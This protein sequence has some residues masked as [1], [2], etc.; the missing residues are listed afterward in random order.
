MRPQ[1]FKRELRRGFGSL[2]ESDYQRVKKFP[3][4]GKLR[5]DEETGRVI[6]GRRITYD[7]R[8]RLLGLSSQSEFQKAINILYRRSNEV[9]ARVLDMTG[10]ENLAQ[11]QGQRQAEKWKV[12]KVLDDS[13]LVASPDGFETVV[14]KREVV[15]NLSANLHEVI[16]EGMPV[17]VTVKQV[18]LQEG[19][20]DLSL[21]K[22]EED[23]LNKYQI[24]QVANGHV[25]N[26]ISAGAFIELEPG[27]QG[28]VHISEVA[29]WRIERVEAILHKGQA[30][31]VRILD[32]DRQERKLSLTMRLPENDPLRS[33]SVNQVVQ[34]KIVGFTKDGSGT[35]VELAPGAEGYVYKDEI[36]FSPVQDARQILKEEQAVTVRITE[37]DMN[38]R[39]MRLTIRG[40]Y[41]ITIRVPLPH[42]RLIKGRGGSTINQITNETQTRID[43]EDDGTCIIQGLTVQSVASAK[44]RIEK[45][46][47]IRIVTFR[48]QEL[49]AK[50]LIGKG[51]ETI[52]GIQ[53]DTGTQIQVDSNT[54]QVTVTAENNRVLQNCIDRIRD[55][56]TYYQV[57]IRVPSH[58]V[59]RV[60]GPSGSNV[61][62]ISQTGVRVYAPRDQP[63]IITIEGK[64]RTLVDQ[65]LQQIRYHAGTVEFIA[66]NEGVM[67]A[68]QDVRPDVPSAPR[69]LRPSQEA[70]SVPSRLPATPSVPQPKPSPPPF[71][72]QT[73]PIQQQYY[74][75]QLRIPL[76]YLPYLLRNQRGF[77]ETLFSGGKSALDQ[78]MEKT[79]TRI[80]VNSTTGDLTAMGRTQNAVNGAIREIKAFFRL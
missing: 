30:V 26:I 72:Q 31:K 49:Q 44:Q 59:G 47:E 70:V 76:N 10:I 17:A 42:I 74:Q 18:D 53:N 79:Q 13:V 45:I 65:A 19:R 22:P 73:Q 15:Y 29:W 40:L 69:T 41:E 28:M 37:L 71:V 34:G 63:G 25:A 36:S 46:L 66:I 33:F 8:M 38:E 11:Y 80:K 23:P 62:A 35:F 12:T 67:P 27:V 2:P 9:E 57:T 48:I 5:F 78:I 20:V 52:K 77:L 1:Q 54:N 50:R 7:Q 4:D 3:W 51:G 58:M 39:R 68:Y 16:T 14:P 60:I 75:A 43:I 24:G 61:K 21:L 6:S 55:I 32:I 56:I 64:S